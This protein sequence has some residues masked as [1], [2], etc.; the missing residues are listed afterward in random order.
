MM[1]LAGL[2]AC[3]LARGRRTT[4]PEGVKGAGLVPVGER[5]LE[6]RGAG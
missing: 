3:P 4:P 1:A 2:G 6:L 5:W